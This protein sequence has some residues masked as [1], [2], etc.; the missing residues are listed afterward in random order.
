VGCLASPVSYLISK[1]DSFE[2]GLFGGSW[3]RRARTRAAMDS[4]INF[5]GLRMGLGC[6]WMLCSVGNATINWEGGSLSVGGVLLQLT[7]GTC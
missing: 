3:R 5:G 7:L 1:I 6:G 4:S 2:T